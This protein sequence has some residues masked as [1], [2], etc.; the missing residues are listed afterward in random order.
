MRFLILD[1]CYPAFLRAHYARSPGLE[2]RPYA[3]QWRSLMDTFFGTADSYSHALGELGHEAREIVANA[4]P[5]QEAWAREHG[6]RSALPFRLRRERLVRDQAA[7]FQPDIVYVQNMR[8]FSRR[9]LADLRRGGA[10]I[11]GQIASE[12][13][14]DGKVR[15]FDL[16]LTSF[17]H[18]VERFRAAGVAS[19]Y[20]RI[21]FDPRVLTRLGAAEAQR[22]RHGAVFVGSLNRTQHSSAN[23]LLERAASRAPIDF[24]GYAADGWPETSPIRARYHGEAWGIDMFRVLYE[25]RIALNRHIGVAEQYANNMRLYEA[26]GVGTMLMTDEKENLPGLFTPGSEVVTY[27]GEDE[28]VERVAYYLEHDEERRAIAAAGQARTLREHTY[29]HRMEELLAILG[30]SHR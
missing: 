21:G 16:V 26:T 24:W 23:A 9:L 29:R 12:A 30:G 1:T 15:A 2:A 5:L 25:S 3:E 10:T 28:L 4:A 6:F 18:F 19:E 22:E 20:L 11:V 14:S 27:S 17:P 7:D 13:P 8:F